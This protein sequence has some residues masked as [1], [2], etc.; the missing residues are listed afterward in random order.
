MG[1]IN[2]GSNGWICV[3]RLDFVFQ[4]FHGF[5]ALGLAFGELG[6]LESFAVLVINLGDVLVDWRRWRKHLRWQACLVTQIF[7][8]LDYQLD[9]LMAEGDSLE[10]VGLGHF[11]SEALNH[12]DG[13]F[14]TSHHEIEVALFQLLVGGHGD[15][16]AIHPPDA[17][18]T[19][20]LE[21]GQVGDVQCGAS[22][23]HSQD[24]GIV[25]LVG[26]QGGDEDLNLV[27]VVDRKERANRAVGQPGS[28][29]FFQAGAGFTLDVT[30]GELAGCIGLFAVI[31]G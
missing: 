31:N 1:G 10:H 9:L 16:L 18:R 26:G 29:G 5:G 30:T 28:E 23:D 14:G 4:F 27:D 24:V 21:E 2:S 15:K 8:R 7:N 22:T 13:A 6:G 11:A 3:L 25:C 12:G 17:H 19:G 20:W